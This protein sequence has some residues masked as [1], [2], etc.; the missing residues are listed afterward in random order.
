M[1]GGR[2]LVV[3]P[4]KIDTPAS[5]R[6]PLIYCRAVEAARLFRMAATIF[7]WRHRLSGRRRRCHVVKHR[8]QK[9]RLTSDMA[10]ASALMPQNKPG[11]AP[12]AD[13][14]MLSYRCSPIDIII[15]V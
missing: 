12:A 15:A 2:R 5:I 6:W 10:S 9:R 7:F 14:G 11:K 4:I 1:A 3:L 13:G 8:H